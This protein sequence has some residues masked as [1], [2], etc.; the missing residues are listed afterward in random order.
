M[1]D[2]WHHIYSL[3]RLN[4]AF[5]DSLAARVEVWWGSAN[6]T[7]LCETWLWISVK[8]ERGHAFCWC[9]SQ[10]RPHG[11]Q[12]GSDG[13]WLCNGSLIMTA[14][15]CGVTLGDF[16]ESS[17]QVGLFSPPHRL[18]SLLIS[19][20]PF[21]LQL[22]GIRLERI[23]YKE[24]LSVAISWPLTHLGF[25]SQILSSSPCLSHHPTQSYL[26]YAGNSYSFFK[27]QFRCY[28]L[29]EAF[30]DIYVTSAAC[31]PHGTQCVPSQAFFFAFFLHCT[32]SC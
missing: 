10:L 17:A 32:V 4:R 8:E 25:H 13:F 22:A 24:S 11:S 1:S 12:P 9:E 3:K 29:H 19:R 18:V 28:L 7:F 16:P 20:N 14:Q 21:L 31:L 30:L 23:L 15:F 26:S 27:T 5:P 2:V 6:Q